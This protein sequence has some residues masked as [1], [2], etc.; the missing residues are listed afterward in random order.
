MADTW[1]ERIA[2]PSIRHV[3]RAVVWVE[4][5]LSGESEARQR[6][7]KRHMKAAIKS[8]EA[9]LKELSPY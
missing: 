1:V 7:A 8:L 9:A 2:V 3:L 5:C 6:K 4:D